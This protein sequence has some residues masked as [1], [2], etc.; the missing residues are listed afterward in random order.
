MGNEHNSPSPTDV[1]TLSKKWALSYCL[2][3]RLWL[4]SLGHGGWLL[5]LV[6]VVLGKVI[7][8]LWQSSSSNT[9]VNQNHMTSKMLTT[10]FFN[11]IVDPGIEDVDKEAHS[12]ARGR[13][14]LSCPSSKL[15]RFS[16]LPNLSYILTLLQQK[17]HCHHLSATLQPSKLHLILGV[18]G[19]CWPPP[20]TNP[21]NPQ[22]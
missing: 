12:M 21:H 20:H 9:H 14:G 16:L 5:M 19:F 10:R 6:V 13:G 18:V 15:V 7:K 11:S 2:G 3:S 22:N 17:T 8:N 4:A 1:I